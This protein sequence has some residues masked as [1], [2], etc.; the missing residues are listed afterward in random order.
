MSSLLHDALSAKLDVPATLDWFR[1]EYFPEVMRRINSKE[2]RCRMALYPG[3]HLRTNERNLTDTR[4]RIGILLEHDFTRIS[5]EIIKDEGIG[6]LVWT[7]VVSN[8]FPDLEVHSSSG[9]PCLRVEMKALES[10]AE[11]KSA[12]FATLIK[13]IN[14]STDYLI[15]CLWQW[16]EK[17]NHEAVTWESAV[18]VKKIFVFHAYSLARIRDYYWFNNPPAKCKAYQGVDIRTAISCN[19]ECFSIEEHNM[20]K[21]LRLWQGETEELPAGFSEFERTT[22]MS[23]LEFVDEVYEAGFRYLSVGILKSIGADEIGYFDLGGFK[24]PSSAK[25]VVVPSKK[26]SSKQNRLLISQASGA[27]II[28]R[29]NGNYKCSA[30]KMYPEIEYRGDSYDAVRERQL[31]NSV[32][33]K[34]VVQKLID[35]GVVVKQP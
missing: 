19:E 26:G 34:C 30:W 29:M 25:I 7:Y 16:E 17:Q 5:N 18:S 28:V 15:I 21:I 32:K 12:N 8:R 10:R 9:K 35:E 14:P 20:G 33:P 11:E 3:D 1:R 4:T 27:D 13:D 22:L 23:Y 6:D 24:C 31:F 2:S